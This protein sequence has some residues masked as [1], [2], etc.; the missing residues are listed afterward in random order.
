MKQ[1]MT[2]PRCRRASFTQV[3]DTRW[4]HRKQAIRRRRKCLAC[5]ERFTT[6]E[7]SSDRDKMILWRGMQ[8]GTA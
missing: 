7:V 6:Y 5:R 4:S 1:G 8:D 2:C 3:M